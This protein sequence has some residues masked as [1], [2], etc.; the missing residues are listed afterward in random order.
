[1]DQRYV[2][3][4]ITGMN[5][6]QLTVTLPPNGHVAPPGAYMLFVLDGAGI[7]SAARMIDVG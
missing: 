6:N 1:M 4:A 7:P 5:P 2:A 3:L